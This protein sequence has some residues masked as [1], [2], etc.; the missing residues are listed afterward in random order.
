MTNTPAAA[1]TPFE[2]KLFAIID[3]MIQER[4]APTIRLSRG[5]AL[6][7]NPRDRSMALS[8]VGARPSEVEIGVVFRI[9]YKL[10]APMLITWP[11]PA[12]EREIDGDIHYIYR[13]SWA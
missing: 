7:Y 6:G 3:N 13:I 12:E 2:G 5:L 8:R 4:R 10:R 9:I 1:P 11:G